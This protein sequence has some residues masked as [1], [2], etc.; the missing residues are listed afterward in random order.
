M[1]GRQREFNLLQNLL[2]EAISGSGSVALVGGEAGVGKTRLCRELSGL[3]TSKGVSVTWGRQ[4]EGP[5]ARVSGIWVELTES[6]LSEYSPVERQAIIGP[7]DSLL[8]E[9]FSLPRSDARPAV[10][11]GLSSRDEEIRFVDSLSRCLISIAK[12]RPVLMVL[13]DMHWADSVAIELFGQMARA[14]GD[15][16]LLLIAT[17]RD[18]ELGP[19]HPLSRMLAVVRRDRH[20][21]HLPV[22]ALNVRE[23]RELATALAPSA[24]LGLWGEAIWN[25]TSGNPFLA[26]ELTRHLAE[27]G[28]FASPP[29]RT[30]TGFDLRSLGV[31][32]GIRQVVNLRIAR[33][34]SDA[35]A[36]LT[37]ASV[38]ASGFEFDTLREMTGFDDDQLLDAID[39]VLQA[40][41]IVPQAARQERY[42]FVHDIAREAIY[43]A[44]SPSRRVRL[45]RKMADAILHLHHDRLP[46]Y[47]AELAVQFHASATLP[48]ADRGVEFALLAAKL[49]NEQAASEHAVAL[50][51]IA[52]ELATYS[53]LEKRIEVTSKLAIAYAHAHDLRASR[54]AIDGLHNLMVE[55]RR[56]L[57]ELAPLLWEVSGA[58]KDGGAD[59]S[60]WGEFVDQGLKLVDSSD[61]LTWARLTL[62]KERFASFSS[63][64][65]NAA[66]WLGVDQEALLI[67]RSE[68]SED[69]FARTLQPFDS[70]DHPTTEGLIEQIATWSSPTAIIR[71]LTVTGAAWLY[72]LADFRRARYHFQ[73]LLQ[74]SERYGSITGQAEAHIRL[75]IVACALGDLT[76]AQDEAASARELLTRLLPNHRLH[77]SLGWIDAYLAEY[78]GGD[79]RSI[80]DMLMSVV[81][82]PRTGKRSIGLDDAALAALALARSG[83][84]EPA[85]RLLNTLAALIESVDAGTALAN[86]AVALGASTAWALDARNVAS[87]FL[88]AAERLI[89]AGIRSFP[90]TSL[91]L[92]AARMATLTGDTTAANRWFELA[93]TQLSS[94]GQRPL[95]AIVDLDEARVL[96]KANSGQSE[97]TEQLLETARSSFQALG[98]DE[99]AAFSYVSL[100]KGRKQEEA[101]PDSRPAG[102]TRREIEVLRLVSQG[103]SDRQISTELYLSPRTVNAH[104]RN[105]LSK[106]ESS[107]RTE[108]SVWAMRNVFVEGSTQESE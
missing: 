15:C 26:E 41:L 70:F 59:S 35:S 54:T 5:S 65:I 44:L 99:W 33:L 32:E 12:H 71:G 4:T 73:Q 100:P 67:A 38:S 61:R 101:V 82:D 48:G 90:C 31:P 78:L 34:S 91:E 24:E 19:S 96:A 9:L 11:Y 14:A 29:P 37:S 84:T 6:L 95:R 53:T 60:E 80:A 43:S 72:H 108:L 22:K 93:R 62:L 63:G 10:P 18:V 16:H 81:E 39:E 64:E 7:D 57:S 28:A 86:G 56:P 79:W 51:N 21:H 103:H 17:Y 50:L 97:R 85:L 40:H 27:A 105:M 102:L 87:T 36:L 92:S 2:A 30:A 58:L 69:D 1:I 77:T 106:T 25:E 13:D 76:E 47:A 20:V 8:K 66:R 68:G 88:N 83:Q 55:A 23:T 104:I 107:N 89:S 45:H 98:M 75:A 42:Q 3:A 52:Q 94:E 46:E 74:V 49:T